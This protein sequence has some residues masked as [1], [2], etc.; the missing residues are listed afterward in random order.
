LV[1]TIAAGDKPMDNQ[2]TTEHKKGFFQNDKLLVC[3]MLVFYGLCI[4]GLIAGAYFW[5]GDRAETSKINATATG[6]VIATE[7]A[8]STSTA[9]ART[10]EQDQYDFTEHFD[11]NSSLW[12]V[13]AYEKRYGDA[14]IKIENG[15]YN[16]KINDAKGFVQSTEFRKEN[17]IKNFD[18]YMDLKLMDGS[19]FG[20]TCSGFYFRMPTDDWN[21]GA[22][23]FVI[24]DNSHY[25]IQY[26]ANNDWQTITYSEYEKTIHGSDWNRIEISARDDQF[27]FTI[28]HINVFEM[29][30][31]RLKFGS[32]GIFIDLEQNGSANILFDNFGF[33]RR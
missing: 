14:Q 25:E 7:Q 18:V 19:S 22:Y 29:T 9:I 10:I 27:I 15:V 2:N 32:L 4:I 24:C 23:T 3:S 33:R 16:W 13:G 28:N 30:D 17:I 5:L 11:K 21:D 8:K 12:F 26:Y 6:A 20:E 1:D 31:D